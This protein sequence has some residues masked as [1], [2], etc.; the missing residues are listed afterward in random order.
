MKID[1]TGKAV[2]MQKIA[3]PFIFKYSKHLKEEKK[4][5]LCK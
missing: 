1:Y 3:I 2:F 5:Q 4:K